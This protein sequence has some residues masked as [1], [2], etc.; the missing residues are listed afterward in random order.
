M[1]KNYAKNCQVYMHEHGSSSEKSSFSKPIALIFSSPPMI[2]FSYGIK[3]CPRPLVQLI[4]RVSAVIGY[5]E[6]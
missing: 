5:I 2:F 1:K 3:I 4:G 6:T